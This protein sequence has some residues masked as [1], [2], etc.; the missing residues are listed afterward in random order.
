MHINLKKLDFLFLNILIYYAF[1]FIIV[2]CQMRNVIT[3]PYTY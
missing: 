2:W 3:W 1:V